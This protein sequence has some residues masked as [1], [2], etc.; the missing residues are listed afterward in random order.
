MTNMNI[1]NMYKLAA[2]LIF[3]L[4]LISVITL[5]GHKQYKKG[6]EAGKSESF[7][8][9]QAAIAEQQ[10]RFNQLSTEYENLKNEKEVNKN[11]RQKQ[12]PKIIKI[13]VYGNNCIDASGLQLINSAI[14]DR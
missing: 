8:T 13:P 11:E 7:K 5:I 14:A 1:F 10:A 4:L 6:F 9:Q 3:I 12:I 2:S